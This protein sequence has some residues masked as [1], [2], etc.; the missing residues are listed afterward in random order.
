MLLYRVGEDG[1]A[2]RD[3]LFVVGCYELCVLSSNA[4]T[5][6]VANQARVC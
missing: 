3:D 6:Q 2:F 5:Y 1:L 4:N